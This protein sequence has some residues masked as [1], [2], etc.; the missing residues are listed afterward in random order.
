MAKCWDDVPPNGAFGKRTWLSFGASISMRLRSRLREILDAPLFCPPPAHLGFPRPG[1]GRIR[2]TARNRSAAQPLP[3]GKASVQCSG[4]VSAF[5]LPCMIQEH[6]QRRPTSSSAG[7]VLYCTVLAN[8]HT[9]CFGRL[10]RKVR[11]FFLAIN[12]RRRRLRFRA[13]RRERRAE[14]RLDSAWR[15]IGGSRVAC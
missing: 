3:G 2:S 9:A 15:R 1:S 6:V 12:W 14:R 13:L 11:G 7:G 8:H 5:S 10:V 4:R